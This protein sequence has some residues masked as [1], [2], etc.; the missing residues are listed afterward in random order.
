VDT[1]KQASHA[2][3]LDEIAWFDIDNF[4]EKFMPLAFP[5]VIQEYIKNKNT[6]KTQYVS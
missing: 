2:F 1:W 3:E 5:K 6:F 4:P